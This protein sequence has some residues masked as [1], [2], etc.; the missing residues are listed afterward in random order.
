MQDEVRPPAARED[1]AGEE[2]LQ[3]EQQPQPL[4]QPRQ[5]AAGKPF[6]IGTADAF[7]PMKGRGKGG[8]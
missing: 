5:P 3:R 7:E 8:G 2:E 6:G 4:R 1:A